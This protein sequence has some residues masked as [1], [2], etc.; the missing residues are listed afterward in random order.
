[1]L[2]EKSWPEK[3]QIFIRLQKVNREMLE[4]TNVALALFDFIQ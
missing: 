4:L 1:M 2:P 3:S